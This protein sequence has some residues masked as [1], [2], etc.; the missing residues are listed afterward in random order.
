MR[1]YRA[2]SRIVAF[3]QPQL[4]QLTCLSHAITAQ[5]VNG[6]RMA[7]AEWSRHLKAISRRSLD[8]G[9]QSHQELWDT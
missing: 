4:D 6:A 2:S 1:E 5:D 7:I 3:P 8:C 9:F